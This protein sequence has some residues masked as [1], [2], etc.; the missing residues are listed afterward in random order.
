[1]RWHLRAHILIFWKHTV[2][3]A[4]RMCPPVCVSQ[5]PAQ[6]VAEFGIVTGRANFLMRLSVTHLHTVK[7]IEIASEPP[8]FPRGSRRRCNILTSK[9]SLEDSVSLPFFISRQDLLNHK[10]GLSKEKT[11]L[12]FFS[13]W[14]FAFSHIKYHF[15]YSYGVTLAKFIKHFIN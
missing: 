9:F 1:M 2:S 8:R 3:S 5:F 7:M 10:M 14:S 15:Y 4:L 12:F 6:I 13:G 11:L